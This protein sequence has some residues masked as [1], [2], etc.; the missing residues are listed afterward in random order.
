MRFEGMTST[1]GRQLQTFTISSTTEPTIA[2]TKLVNSVWDK[3]GHHNVSLNAG[4]F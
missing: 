3:K 1:Y 2:V 4:P